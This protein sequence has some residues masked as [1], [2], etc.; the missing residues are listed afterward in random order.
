MRRVPTQFLTTLAAAALL[1]G[2]AALPSLGAEAEW[3]APMAPLM[4]AG[5]AR[6]KTP[7]RAAE[8]APN[9]PAGR[10]RMLLMKGVQLLRAQSK[11]PVGTTATPAL[12]YYGG[13]MLSHVKIQVVY[14]NGAVK[15][16]DQIPGFY[17]AITQSPYFDW[18]KEYDSGPYKIGR[19]VLLGAYTD[20][21]PNPS[22]ALEDADVQAEL[23]SLIGKSAV[24]QPDADT[25]YMMYFP[26]GVSIDMQGSGSCQVFCA[27]H[28]TFLDNGKEVNYGVIP[29]QG[30][31]C[32]GGCGT[33]PV[34]FN[35][36]TSVSSHEMIEAVTDPAVGLVT[37]NEP[38]APL[39][40]YDLNYGEIGD[41]C[42]AGQAKVGGYTVQREWSN[43]RGLCV[44]SA[45]D[46][47]TPAGLR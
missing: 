47:G 38:V 12:K 21:S 4:T 27:Y 18:L 22:A 41:I 24:P 8:R 30:G 13:P 23:S 10:A 16:Q 14:W 44:S 34:E 39:G 19:G 40:W 33:D 26:P 37:G 2:A 25:L 43:A 36:E 20:P 15:H 32:A 3:Y 42:N 35:N 46:A 7:A 11:A 17:S 31:S 28:G 9:K 1:L 6:P 45:S 29:D 5:A